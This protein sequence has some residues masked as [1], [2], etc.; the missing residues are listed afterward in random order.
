MVGAAA[1]TEVL[2]RAGPAEAIYEVRTDGR[3]VPKNFVTRLTDL[4]RR[5]VRQAGMRSPEQTAVTRS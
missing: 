4:E 1:E 3:G 2:V 5:L